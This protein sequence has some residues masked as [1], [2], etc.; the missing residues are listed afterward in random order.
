MER[1]L[2]EFFYSLW[3]CGRIILNN[4]LSRKNAFGGNI[5]DKSVGTF[6]YDGDLLVIQNAD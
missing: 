1:K 2:W 5:I 6:D 3:I 4:A